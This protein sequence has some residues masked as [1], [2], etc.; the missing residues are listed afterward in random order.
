VNLGATE[1]ERVYTVDLVISVID[2]RF[3]MSVCFLYID[4]LVFV[5]NDA[6]V[7]LAG[8]WTNQ[9]SITL[10]TI[11]KGKEIIACTISMTTL[12]K[13]YFRSHMYL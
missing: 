10:L 3:L 8:H 6:E 1:V 13:T 5:V 12:I 9:S 7:L 4:E 2:N 11:G